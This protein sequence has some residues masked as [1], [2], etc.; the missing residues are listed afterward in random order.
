MYLT[1]NQRELLRQE[2]YWA[3][4]L[5]LL[6]KGKIFRGF[7]VFTGYNMA[8]FRVILDFIGTGENLAKRRR[9]IEKASEKFAEMGATFKIFAEIA[10]T[11]EDLNEFIHL[12]N[13]RA[14]SI[15]EKLLLAA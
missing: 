12:L 6:P 5:P 9:A 14:L 7:I 13:E 15:N 1:K 3:G 11:G 8:P 4:A 2:G 10:G